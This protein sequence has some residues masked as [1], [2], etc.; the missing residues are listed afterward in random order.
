MDAASADRRIVKEAAEISPA[1]SSCNDI[2]T[3]T[4]VIPS[5]ARKE[6]MP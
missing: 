6:R 1:A 4:D 3:V 2:A 5:Q